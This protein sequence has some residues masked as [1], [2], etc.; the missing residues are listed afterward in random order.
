MR[1]P[2]KYLVKLIRKLFE[3]LQMEEVEGDLSEEYQTDLKMKGS[4]FATY[5]YLIN[6]LVLVP[7]FLRRN[8]KN[9][10]QQEMRLNLFFYLKNALRS[11]KKFKLYH[12]INILSL[13][14]GF[15]CFAVIYLFVINHYQKDSFL[16][17]RDRIVRLATIGDI[18]EGSSIHTALAPI[19]NNELPEIEAFAQVAKLPVSITKINDDN[20]FEDFMYSSDSGFIDIFQLD[21]LQGTTPKAQTREILISERMSTK[22]YGNTNDAIGKKIEAGS[23]GR[24][25]EYTVVGILKDQPINTS[26][27]IDFLRIW[28]LD[29]KNNGL[30][31]QA[32]TSYPSFFKISKNTTPDLLLSKLKTV[33]KKHTDKENVLEAKY[34]FRTFDEIKANPSIATSFIS[35]IDSEALL[36][37]QI[38]GAIVL[39]LAAANYMNTTAALSLKRIQETGIRRIMGAS[40]SSLTTQQLIEALVVGLICIV[41][42]LL[43]VSFSIKSIESFIN[44][45]LLFTS[46]L[47]LRIIGIA[48]STFVLVTLTASLYPALLLKSFTF[49]HFLKGKAN[50]SALSSWIRNSLLILQFSIATFLILGCLTFLKQMSYI[51]SQHQKG[52]LENLIVIKGEI[53]QPD[54][55][56][57]ELNKIPEISMLSLS[58]MVPGV[59]ARE[60]IGIGMKEFKSS[61]DV[62]IIDEYYLDILGLEV[63]DGNNFFKDQ[64]N[65]ENHVL[66]NE[67]LV[68]KSLDGYPLDK[69][70]QMMYGGELRKVVGIVKDFPT[71]SIKNIIEPAAFFQ[72]GQNK[73]FKSSK[74]RVLIKVE[75]ASMQGVL[76]QIE[77][78]WNDLSPESAFEPEYMT[79][80]IDEIYV[81]E[82]KLGKL[83]GI[84]TG[85]AIFIACIGIFGL[86]SFIIQ[87]RIKEIGIRK[88]LG[89]TFG[90]IAQILTKRLWLLLLLAI[91][92]AYPLSYYFLRNWLSS[93]AYRTQVTL[94]LYI[95]TTTIFVLIIFVTVFSHLKKASSI[96]PSEVLKNE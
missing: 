29:E 50:K 79:D 23:Y 90:T 26:F 89:A 84:F 22:L 21:L 94:D 7:T 44:L 39:I 64:R 47:K 33:L 28:N 16:T 59:D 52:D 27:N 61:F 36:I 95:V 45:E 67:A 34:V 15:S 43:I 96:S 6:L 80:R 58:S 53:E 13:T 37:F 3:P 12:T 78:I 68:E 83:F 49:Q 10:Q 74:N 20:L 69:E 72:A 5:K 65:K 81:E 30:N 48:L 18:K 19:L 41:L 1:K 9:K 8:Q 60:R 32:Y 91:T 40:I 70:Y 17:N 93:F 24:T 66:M 54:V 42:T 82:V 92:I 38:V 4:A 63:I 87:T 88:V 77:T 71:N 35:S 46:S 14:L 11:I 51:H 76:K 57:A 31:A 75:E 62:H 85:I 25:T 56:R 55:L 73:N 2:P 86:L